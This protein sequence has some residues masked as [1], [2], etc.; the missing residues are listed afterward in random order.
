MKFE[1][2]QGTYINIV[3]QVEIKFKNRFKLD[4]RK[5]HLLSLLKGIH[6]HHISDYESCYP[7]DLSSKITRNAVFRSRDTCRKGERA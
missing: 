2:G 4:Y 1:P 5:S 3:L 6:L 7:V